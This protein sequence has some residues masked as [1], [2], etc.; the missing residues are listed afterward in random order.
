M[1]TPAPGEVPT[2]DQFFE[3]LRDRIAVQRRLDEL[4]TGDGRVDATA[5]GTIAATLEQ[6]ARFAR[7]GET[8]PSLD[9]LGWPRRVIAR[10]GGR[11]MLYFLRLLSVEQQRFNGLVVRALR[12]LNSNARALHR[13]LHAL[14]DDLVSALRERDR[15]LAT[16][17]DELA[18]RDKRLAALRDAIA[19]GQRALTALGG[20]G[21]ERDRRL[22]A[23]EAAAGACARDVGS[24]AAQQATADR[25]LADLRAGAAVL[26]AQL[27]AL[28]LRAT[29]PAAA[30]S[31]APSGSAPVAPAAEPLLDALVAA[32]VLR[33]GEA[34]ITA[35]QRE[36]VPHF[37]GCRDVLDV[38][39][40]RGEFLDLLRAAGVPARGVDS[41][42][43]MVLRCREKGLDV[44]R[45][46]ALAHLAELPDGS[47]GG[48]FCAQVIEHWRT[49]TVVAF[50]RQAAR[51]LAPGA[52]LVIETL[53]PE[54]LLVLYRW[55]WLDLTHERLVHP[56]ALQYLLRAAGFEGLQCVYASPPDGALR[57]PPLAIAG[58]DAAALQPFNA[59]TQYLNDLLYG[60]YD[61]AVVARR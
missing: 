30:P 49:P 21:A 37:S 26:R 35:R 13:E 12:G 20:A 48:L 23:L 22:A 4:S 10:A 33:S 59:A 8:M 3:Q 11:L 58:A 7:V 25:A 15:R 45:A 44:A 18:E 43:D 51:T 60:S 55:F 2:A 47:L 19:D 41:D 57:I 61:Y 1:P 56:D 52:P 9:H 24:L 14:P 27:Q 5:F 39:C 42:A 50:V 40:G 34:D 31:S 16:H 53:N 38:G 28:Q 6:A 36:Y 46:D 29:A 32:E 54:S 17:E